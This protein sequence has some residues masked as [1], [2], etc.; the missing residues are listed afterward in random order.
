MVNACFISVFVRICHYFGALGVVKTC[1]CRVFQGFSIQG[2]R[3]V[4][5]GFYG[6]AGVE[7]AITRA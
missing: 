4:F 6:V 7:V 2:I 3:F 5:D 1:N